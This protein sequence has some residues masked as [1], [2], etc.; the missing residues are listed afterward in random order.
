MTPGAMTRDMRSVRVK[1]SG[2]GKVFQGVRGDA[3]P[4]TVD[5]NSAEGPSPTETL[6]MS[7]AA[8]MAIDVREI[9][10]KGRV[11][12]SDLVVEVDGDRAGEPPRRFTALRISVWV[13]G[14]DEADR[15]KVERAA[16]LSHEK[17]CSVFHT[18]RRD[19]DVRLTTS[20]A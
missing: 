11:P 9:L 18:F 14:P 2:H 19:L 10:E 4:I 15:P 13:S 20:L 1:W 16:R 12:I 7:L 5:G 6:L 8:C 3:P 17:Y